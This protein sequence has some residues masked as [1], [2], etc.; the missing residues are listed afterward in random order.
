MDA[1]WDDKQVIRVVCSLDLLKTWIVPAEERD[2]KIWLEHVALVRVATTGFATSKP[3]EHRS[4]CRS[5]FLS[6][7]LDIRRGQGIAP[8]LGGDNLAE[9]VKFHSDY[10]IRENAHMGL[11]RAPCRVYR[12]IDV[13]IGSHLAY[14]NRELGMRPYNIPEKER[15]PS[16][17]ES[18]DRLYT[19]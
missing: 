7:R 11:C 10:C 13:G 18:K 5:K 3:R 4:S 6:H 1:N 2:A 19:L 16:N 14:V 9:S 15:T 17:E 12:G 8:T